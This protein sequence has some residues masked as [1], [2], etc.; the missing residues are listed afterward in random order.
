M[1]ENATPD[2]EP[3]PAPLIERERLRLIGADELVFARAPNG[4]AIRLTIKDTISI[5]NLAARA[6]FPV[7]EPDAM[8]ELYG[9]KPDGS[10]GKAFG[11]LKDIGALDP[12][13][14]A[15]LDDAIARVRLV[16]VI[17]RIIELSDD[18]HSFRWKI[19]TD[20]GE[21]NFF[22]GRPRDHIQRRSQAKYL[23]TDLDKSRYEIADINALDRR[24]RKLL[25]LVT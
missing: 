15:L 3:K 23:I 12:A 19:E 17:R 2:A 22:T 18:F 21:F 14:R 5:L 13:S 10:V 24:S 1:S 16:P 11:M 8:I 4:E 25:E 6:A 20:R 7:E 9:V